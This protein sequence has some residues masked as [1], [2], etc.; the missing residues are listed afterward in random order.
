[1]ELD[2]FMLS[3]ILTALTLGFHIIFA[4]IG[5]GVPVMIMIAEWMGIRKKDPH[6]F[7]LARRWA[8]G[9]TVTVAVGVVT[10]TCI[11]LQLSLLW[12]RFMQ[13][14]GQVIAL[15]LFLEVFAFF[16]EAIFL[17]IYL[18]TWD[19]FRNR[20]SH[21]LLVIPVVIGSS[22]SAFFITTVNA[23]MNTPQGFRFENGVITGIEPIKAMFNPATPTK[24][25]H[26]LSSAYLT[27]AFVLAAITAWF[28]LRG[29]RS[30]YYRKALRLTM[31]WSL[32][33]AV[34]TAIIGD[35][36]GKFLADYQPEKLAAAEWHFETQR[37]ADLIIGGVLDK[38]TNEVKGALEIPGALSILAHG[39]PNAEVKGLNEFPQEL[40]P[41]LYVHYLFDLMVGIGFYLT[42][43][44]SLF[45]WA[46]VWKKRY[47]WN[48]WLLRLI[49]LGGPLSM[50]AIEFGWIFTEV[51]RQ[52]WILRG[53]MRTGEG[54]TSAANV[55][56]MLVLFGALY[57]ALGTVC[58]YVLLRMFRKNP[59][60][61]EMQNRGIKE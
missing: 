44:A 6:Y 23:F 45:I 59:P 43:V 37:Q 32:I 47:E 42:I 50:A 4:T 11:G 20:L 60:E 9:F 30:E 33:F 7:L 58:S 56:E 16:F 57:L 22:A 14:A 28:I 15:P 48:P 13:M 35:L 18:Y 54:V 29:K 38:E 52:P 3:R 40:W 51:G 36:S 5:V 19:R 46:R 2:T 31:A 17:G 21:W 53:Y 1:M 61:L 27:A 8:R 41:P 26:V 25:A 12:P 55:G 10:G 49:V 34:S 24:V 39:S